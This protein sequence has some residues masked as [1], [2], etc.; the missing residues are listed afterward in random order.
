MSKLPGNFKEDLL[1]RR[2][3]WLVG[4]MFH[5][6]MHRN[7]LAMAR[8]R[9]FTCV[10]P[11]ESTREKENE[12]PATTDRSRRT[13]IKAD[14]VYGSSSSTSCTH[15]SAV[16]AGLGLR[17]ARPSAHLS[18][19]P[20]RTR[21]ITCIDPIW[22]HVHAHDLQLPTLSAH[23]SHMH[24]SDTDIDVRTHA[25]P[26]RQRPCMHACMQIINGRDVCEQS[27]LDRK[28]ISCIFSE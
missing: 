5:D 23:L 3:I 28:H 15:L 26:C 12:K 16:A 2:N 10:P 27:E 24:R 17:P 18:P 11:R 1:A 22:T 4:S 9:A 8:S 6:S 14:T 19:G 13:K 20:A 7:E 21:L 25:G